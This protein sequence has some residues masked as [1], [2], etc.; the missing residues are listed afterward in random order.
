[1]AGKL[2]TWLWIS[3]ALAIGGALLLYPIGPGAANVVFICVKVGMVSGLLILL[4][5]QKIGGFCLWATC[6][7]LAVVMTILK[8]VFTASVTFLFI[9]SMFV[10]IFMPLMAW[11]FMKEKPA[12]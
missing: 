8:C 9:G 3:V 10:D 5:S 6:S 12:S 11:H 1:M 4:F 7:G 2:K